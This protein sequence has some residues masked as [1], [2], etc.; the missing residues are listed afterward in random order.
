[1]S[2]CVCVSV[3]VC[4]R[5]LIEALLAAAAAPRLM[6]RSRRALPPPSPPR[7]P[8]SC[9]LP[10]NNCFPNALGGASASL[11]AGDMRGWN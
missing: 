2:V 3:H 4:V 9:L 1:M 10:F 11:S 6:R 8:V 7:P 5:R